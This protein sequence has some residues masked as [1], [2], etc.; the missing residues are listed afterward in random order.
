VQAS[1]LAR[2][3]TTL[4]GDTDRL[5]VATFNVENLDPGDG[6]AK[7]NA[8]ANAIV[9]NL[10]APDILSLEEVQDN[11][12][13]VNNGVVDASVTLQTLV[14][15]IAAAG[16]PTYEYRQINPDNNQDGG[17]PGGNIRVAFLFNPNRVGFV[18]GSL[19]RLTD[20]T[21][22]DG[23]AFASSRK[24][25]VG[26]FT[27]NGEDVT[28]VGNHFNSKGGDQPL[29]G[30][31]QPPVLTSEHQR[32]AQATIVA[33]FVQNALK[34]DAGARV[35]VAGDLND[36]EFSRPLTVLEDAGMHTLVETLPANERYT[37]NFQGN[38]QVLDHILVTHAL[39]TGLDGFDVVHLNSEFA[40]QVSDHDP[41]VARF[42]IAANQAPTA[43][44]FA[45]ATTSLAENT[46]TSTRIKLADIVVADDGKG[47]NVL[48]LIGADAGAFE[49]DGAALF[50][51]SGVALD[52]EAQRTYVFSVTVDDASVGSTPD[53][54]AAFT[55]SVPDVN[56][57]P[58]AGA[59]AF[60]PPAGT[61]LAIPVASL[62]ANDRDVDAGDTL[63]VIAVSAATGGSAVLSDNGTPATA[64]DFVTFT[65]S[66]SGAGGFRYTL[67]D[68]GGN[69][70]LGQVTVL[71]GTSQN[72]GNGNDTLTGN[73]GPDRLDGGN[74]RDVLLGGSG[75]DR[76]FGNNGDDSLF[77][78]A[79]SDVLEGGNGADLL[80]GG[81]D[82]DRLVG[83]NGADTYR[84]A[85][86][87]SPL[88]SYDQII[89]LHIG[90]DRIDGPAAVSAALLAQL[91]S[92]GA[93]TE[94]GI[95][96]VLTDAAFAA[97]AAATF[98]FGE[99][100]FLALN[101]GLAGFQEAFDAVIEIT[102]Y[103]GSLSDLAIT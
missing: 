76:L 88:A 8:I 89:G 42:L 18:E 33:G 25:L 28:G 101:D 39:R 55:L 29:F 3:T 65:P 26:T 1:T 52:F 19:Q 14:N 70:D 37:Y 9:T 27:F 80:V 59:D 57:P 73:D 83:G 4:A 51:R 56:E 90:T 54:E 68:G 79:G 74:G 49:I 64:D 45:S 2:E 35:I 16:G 41:V 21:L 92:V 95:G 84:F 17:E 46:S 22:A 94:D 96:A 24:P 81:A 63:A 77:G 71:V 62:L 93:L 20:T 103:S 48:G 58:V 43:I 86:A 53:A 66:A 44:T 30:P 40:V 31:N 15:A 13:P 10:R 69:T 6:A 75:N 34:A 11:N 78:G 67:R 61:P 60:A 47:T 23:D 32:V 87:D 5:S 100:T 102:G 82:G 7:F 97:N 85:L 99:R 72:G 91:A 38:A 36:F 50:L 98:G 12:G